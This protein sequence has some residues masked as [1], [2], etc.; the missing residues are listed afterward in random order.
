MIVQE[1]LKKVILEEALASGLDNEDAL[2]VTELTFQRWTELIR[3]EVPDRN[4]QL[5]EHLSN[6]KLLGLLRTAT[7]E[8]WEKFMREKKEQD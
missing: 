6:E 8:I 7:D 3:E 4:T 5:K 1:E 2:Q